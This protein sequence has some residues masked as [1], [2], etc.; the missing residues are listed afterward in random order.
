MGERTLF[1]YMVRK[2]SV[3]VVSDK[4]CHTLRAKFLNIR[5]VPRDCVLGGGGVVE[6]SHVGGVATGD[7]MMS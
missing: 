2:I 7:T 1:E 4:I 5:W 6:G 3:L